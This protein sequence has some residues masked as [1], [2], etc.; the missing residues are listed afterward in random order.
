L[1]EIFDVKEQAIEFLVSSVLP[2]TIAVIQSSSSGGFEFLGS[3]F[4]LK[5][6][7]VFFFITAAHV[8][9]RAYDS[10]LYMPIPQQE[11]LMPLNEPFLTTG[12]VEPKTRRDDRLDIGIMKL[13]SKKS[14][15]LENVAYLELDDLDLS[16]KISRSKE[17]YIL[18][19]PV[20]KNKRSI[21]LESK[22]I[23]VNSFIS[24]CNE[25]KPDFYNKLNGNYS[26]C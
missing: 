7:D 14:V 5:H 26:V 10:K 23:N 15:V 18:G 12:T 19:Y 22:T 25:I 2:S 4:L 17:Y 3:G 21:D 24:I 11:V 1:D 9:D 20:S 16:N 6:D 13:A 8:L